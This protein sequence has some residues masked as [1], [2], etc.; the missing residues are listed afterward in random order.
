MRMLSAES[1]IDFGRLRTGN[2]SE[3]YW[4]PLARKLRADCLMR[5]ILINDNRGLTVQSLRAEGTAAQR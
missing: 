4:R 2:F 5:P 3:D 1:R